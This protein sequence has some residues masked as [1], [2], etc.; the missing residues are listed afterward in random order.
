MIRETPARNLNKNIE[1]YIQ[2]PLANLTGMLGE[3]LNLLTRSVRVFNF[4]AE[5][6]TLCALRHQQQAEVLRGRGQVPIKITD[7]C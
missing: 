3:T 7:Q 5:I 6:R 4:L 2:D 1:F